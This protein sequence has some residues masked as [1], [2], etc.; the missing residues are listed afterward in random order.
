MRNRSKRNERIAKLSIVFVSLL[1]GLFIAEIFLRVAGYSYPL[2]YETDAERGYALRPGVEG[3]YHKEGAAYVRINSAG[4]RDREHSKAKPPDTFRIA[5]IGDSY[6]EALQVPAEDTFWTV[7]EG[8]LRGCRKFAGKNLEIINFGVSGYGTAQELI[9]LRRHVWDYAPDMV[10]LAFTTNN[11]I[12]DNSRALK[13]TNEIPY[14]VHRDGKLVLDDSFAETP[15]FRLRDSTLNRLGRWIRDGSRVIQAIHQSQGAIKAYVAAK[16]TGAAKPTATEK[17]TTTT[18][19]THNEPPAQTE[20][21]SAARAKTTD[22]LAE[23][24]I[25]NLIY[26]APDN[27]MWQDAWRVTEELL[28]LMR[29]E[30]KSHNAAFVVVTLSNGVQVYPDREARE[31]FM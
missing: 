3:W 7:L 17:P 21:V 20:T 5:L 6:A 18:A 16:R 31:A 8:R 10:L 11:D 19:A 30:V 2:F 29:D 15:A 13:K 9:T 24:G 25:D 22:D 26:R 12:T 4:L 14:F 28:V 23:A 1:A 27:A